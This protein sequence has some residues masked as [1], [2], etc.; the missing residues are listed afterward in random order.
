MPTRALT[1]SLTDLH[2]ALAR[3]PDLDGADRARLQ[4]AIAE[5]Q[6]AL[7]AQKPHPPDVVDRLQA[8][9]LGFEDRHP[10][11]T[12]AVEQLVDAV[13]RAGM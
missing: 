5:I 2:E 10:A 7:A 1:H 4:G 11:L 13:R 8:A 9:A 12:H 6:Q 3:H